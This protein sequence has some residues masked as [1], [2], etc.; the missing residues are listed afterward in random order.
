MK[1]IGKDNKTPVESPHFLAMLRDNRDFFKS[2]ITVTLSATTLF[3]ASQLLGGLLSLPI[4]TQVSNKNFQLL[5]IIL[6]SLIALY[7]IIFALKKLLRF[8]FASIGLSVPGLRSLVQVIPAFVLYFLV[9]AGFTLLA[10]K[11]LPGFDA[12]Q[13]QDVGF[14]KEATNWQLIAAFFSLV[15]IT[16]VFEET[17]FRGILFKR[18][19]ARLS[20]K[21][22][23]I[24]ASVVFAV[25]HM[26]WNVAVD[27]FAL[28]L[29]LC[30]LVE[31]SGSIAPAIAL[32]SI[33]NGLAFVLL[34]IVK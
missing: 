4:I 2:P 27:T 32:H 31:K 7:T 1:Q 16:P 18:L 13:T 33:K 25:A 17:I 3:F 15:I 21:S 6:C 10:V 20:F 30:W 23:I 26:Q 8:R 5:A 14:A 22:S 29:V 11:F 28:S 19:R 9:S 12:E 24:I 34:F